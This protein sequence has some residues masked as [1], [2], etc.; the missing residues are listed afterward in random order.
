MYIFELYSY[1]SVHIASMYIILILCY[2][3]TVT[4]DG[5]ISKS[6]STS[7]VKRPL[8]GRDKRFNHMALY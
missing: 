8:G 2:L 7:A 6:L 5:G 3:I 1:T 4:T